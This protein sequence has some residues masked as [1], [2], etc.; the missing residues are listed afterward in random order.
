[1]PKFN[2][3][4]S[5]V[6]L[7]NTDIML[8]DTQQATNTRK[9]A[10]S[11]LRTQLQN[12]SKSVFALKGEVATDEQVAD[13][14]GDWLEEHVTPTMPTVLVD[15]TLSIEDAAAEAK[16]TGDAIDEVSN[17][18][19]EVSNSVDELKEHINVVGQQP[20]F[21]WMIGKVISTSG[22]ITDGSN[23][24]MSQSINVCAG[25]TF[26]RLTP[27]TTINNIRLATQLACYYF[28]SFVRR[29]SVAAGTTYTIPDGVNRIVVFFLHPTS[30]ATDMTQETIDTYF[31]CILSRKAVIYA[32][33]LANRDENALHY[34][35]DEI[36][37]SIEDIN[38]NIKNASFNSVTILFVTDCHWE[39][40]AKHSPY[41][42][43]QIL[44]RCGVNY[45]INLGDNLAGVNKD[46]QVATDEINACIS[47][48]RGQRLPMLTLNG[49]HDKNGTVAHPELQFSK[50]QRCNM[51]YN[52]WIADSKYTIYSGNGFPCEGVVWED[53]FF[54]YICV[55]DEYP[56]ASSTSSLTWVGDACD[57]EKPIVILTHEIYDKITGG[58]ELTGQY[59]LDAFEPYKNKILCFIQG[60]VHRDGLRRAWNTVPI[61]ILDQDTSESDS[62]AGTITEQSLSAVTIDN[63]NNTINV[64]KIGRGSD[65]VVDEN[66]SDFA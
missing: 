21:E 7:N 11:D 40:N 57:S 45:F 36:D 42:S 33:E 3:Y 64:V 10:Y 31:N 50:T 62:T 4:P 44:K 26:Q 2:A 38:N 6:Q 48:F 66:T 29:V 41:I 23:S 34:W 39:T 14:V 56:D 16:A 19:D 1:M 12:E 52:E 46:L 53:N 65:F 13:A 49:N 59:I 18:V 17:S 9:I 60:H 24:A 35:Q 28:G 54:R 25:D 51:I 27:G 20:V 22:V 15:D 32:D 47:A 58:D 37:D 5:T 43:D 63:D 61:I 30:E 8:A 55:A